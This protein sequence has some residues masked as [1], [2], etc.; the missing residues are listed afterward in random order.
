MTNKM[1]REE[2]RKWDFAESLFAGEQK[3]EVRRM[4]EE[5][6]EAK[7]FSQPSEIYQVRFYAENGRGF[8]AV[9]FGAE[10]HTILI[11]DREHAIEIARR[12][13]MRA[14]TDKRIIEFAHGFEVDSAD[15]FAPQF[16]QDCLS[17]EAYNE[18]AELSIAELREMMRLERTAAP[19][20]Q[21]VLCHGFEIRMFP[22]EDV[23]ALRKLVAAVPATVAG[24]ED[25]PYPADSGCWCAATSSIFGIV[26]LRQ[27]MPRLFFDAAEWEQLGMLLYVDSPL[28][29]VVEVVALTGKRRQRVTEAIWNGNLSA[30]LRPRVHRRRWRI[31]RRAAREWCGLD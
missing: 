24:V 3:E 4:R 13:V 2:N 20:P 7:A 27:G 19:V 12:A 9:Q 15:P 10:K 25:F 18:A 8:A 6:V 16:A 14:N 5:E 11:K 21:A 29:T 30:F 26:L 22:W 23:L 28:L 17:R 31:P 1:T